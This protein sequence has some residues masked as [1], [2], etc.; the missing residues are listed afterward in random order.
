MKSLGYLVV[1]ALALT[2]CT[3]ADKAQ[4]TLED[5][6]YTDIHMTGYAFFA[7]SSDDTFHDGFTAKSPSG[8]TVEGVVCG[9]LLKG[10]TI[11][12]D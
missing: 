7:C 12:F 2:G 6:G 5:Q 8:K 3:R 10:S 1:C 9:G 11:R 4:S